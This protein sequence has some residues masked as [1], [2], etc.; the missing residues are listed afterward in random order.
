MMPDRNCPLAG[1]S[2]DAVFCGGNG[3]VKLLGPVLW[4]LQLVSAV[5]RA[6]KTLARG[7]TVT[8]AA[9]IYYISIMPRLS[10]K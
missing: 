4:A 3:R 7:P 6:G 8:P 10:H 5:G 2:A 9:G 1:P